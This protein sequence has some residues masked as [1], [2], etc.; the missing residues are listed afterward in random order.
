[1][2]LEQRDQTQ[3]GRV[4]LAATRTGSVLIAFSGGADSAY[5][6]AVASEV[7]G[8]RAVAVTAI[9]PAMPSSEV[10]ESR[11]TARLLGIHHETIETAELESAEYTR[12]GTDRCHHRKIGLFRSGE[13]PW[14][15]NSAWPSSPPQQC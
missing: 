5:L 15:T 9:S 1:M 3:T 8:S 2:G 12:N 4:V 13:E 11:E 6:A 10:E 7:L 14:P